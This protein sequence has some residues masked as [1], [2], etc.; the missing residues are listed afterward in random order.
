MYGLPKHALHRLFLIY[1]NIMKIV[2]FLISFLFISSSL[3][4][5]FARPSFDKS[6]DLLLVNFDLKPDE[7]DVMAAAAFACQL[8]HADFAG[9]NYYVVAGAYGF[10]EHDFIEIAVPGFY[11][12]LFGSHKSNW[13]NAHHNWK[14]SVKRATNKVHKV[15]KQ[16]G[17][18][19]IAEAGQS[20]FTFD[21][22]QSLLKKGVPLSTIKS[23][24]ILVQHS[25]W[26]EKMT[27]QTKLEWVKEN[28]N[29]NK[30]E[31]GNKTNRTPNYKDANT[32][33]LKQAKNS[34][35]TFA[36]AVWIEAAQIC[37]EWN[38]SWDNEVITG[39]GV[40]FSDV[41]ELWWI[42]QLENKANTIEAFWNTYVVNEN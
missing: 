1:L 23:K 15:I 22:C 29:Y 27:N 28:T 2:A 24:M 35:N 6:K 14:A 37:D 19:F 31:D 41:V 13:T 17:R 4:Q 39:G 5:T 26:N 11:N 21:V 32:T 8:H 40:D 34:T 7:D 3:L 12:Q 25:N 16:G 30:I 38:A 42:F 18:I 9:V 10:Q 33:W 36:K 20:D